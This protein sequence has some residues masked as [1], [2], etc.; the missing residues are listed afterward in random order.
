MRI[1]EVQTVQLARG[2]G[3]EGTFSV[4]GGWRGQFGA[5]PRPVAAAVSQKCQLL[6]GA[7]TVAVGAD[8]LSAVVYRSIHW[9]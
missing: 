8:K 9:L 2:G 1:T 5:R 6:Y 3:A 7:A 4:A